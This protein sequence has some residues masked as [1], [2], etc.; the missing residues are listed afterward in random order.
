MKENVLVSSCLI[1]LKTRYD[2]KSSK[3]IFEELNSKYN[4]IPF[5]PEQAAGL[6]TPRKPCEIKGGSVYN[7]DGVDLT[8]EFLDGANETL[9][10]CKMYNIK[11]AYLK[12]KSPSCGK[13]KI[14]DGSFSGVLIDGDGIVTKLLEENEIEVISI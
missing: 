2:K 10:L 1:G 7:I 14:Y 8:K 4:I 6:P 3:N 9:K 12:A 5:C 13:G 11:K